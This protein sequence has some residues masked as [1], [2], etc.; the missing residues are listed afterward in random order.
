[1]HP[2]PVYPPT[3]NAHLQRGEKFTTFHKIVSQVSQ[4]CPIVEDEILNDAYGSITFTARRSEILTITDCG[5]Q[6]ITSR[7]GTFWVNGISKQRNRS[8]RIIWHAW[9]DDRSQPESWKGRDLVPKA[10]CYSVIVLWQQGILPNQVTVTCIAAV[11]RLQAPKP[12]RISQVKFSLS[13]KVCFIF[14]LCST[15][16]Q[17]YHNSCSKGQFWPFSLFCKYICSHTLCC[18]SY[19]LPGW[20]PL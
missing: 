1:M 11:Y 7:C 20:I 14:L 17:V 16:S 9:D 2:L 4:S 19:L 6:N 15:G 18:K 12:C 13:I 3:P 10:I 8:H 5:A